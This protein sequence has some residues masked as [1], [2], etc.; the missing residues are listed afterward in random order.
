[1]TE[2]SNK[3]NIF[4]D[5]GWTLEDETRSNRPSTEWAAMIVK[6]G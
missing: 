2:A 3:R 6:P 1:M 4:F 5:L